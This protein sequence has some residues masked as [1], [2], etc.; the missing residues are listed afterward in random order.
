MSRSKLKG[1]VKECL[2]EILAEGLEGSTAKLTEKK[3]LEEKRALEEKALIERR[4]KLETTIDT[5]VSSL[6]DDSI[7]QSILADTARNT[8]QE[9]LSHEGTRPGG[10]APSN[11]GINLDSIFQESQSNW[12]KLAFTGKKI[13]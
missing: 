13:T 10:L 1:I 4:K 7:M 9:Q 2:V 3:N 6:T 8:L 12:E 5:T 11:P